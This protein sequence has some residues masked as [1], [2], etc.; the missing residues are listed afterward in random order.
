MTWSDKKREAASFHGGNHKIQKIL[1]EKTEKHIGWR[2]TTFRG[3][4]KGVKD[5]PLN[6]DFDQFGSFVEF[7][8]GYEP[9]YKR[10]RKKTPGKMEQKTPRKIE[11][12]MPRKIKQKTLRKKPKKAANTVVLLPPPQKLLPAP[13]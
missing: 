10:T 11:Q 5:Y 2:V 6:V 1:D 9:C 3:K 8:S 12:K 4:K 13:K 7:C